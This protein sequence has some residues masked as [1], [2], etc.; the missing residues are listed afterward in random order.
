[1]QSIFEKCELYISGRRQVYCSPR[2][3]LKHLIMFD[4]INYFKH[5]LTE[6]YLLALF[7]LLFVYI[8]GKQFAPF[9]VFV[10]LLCPCILLEYVINMHKLLTNELTAASYHGYN[11]RSRVIATRKCRSVI[12]I[13]YDTLVP[14]EK[15]KDLCEIDH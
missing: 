15:S 8:S 7:E 2:M 6:K 9:Y 3:P 10:F 14:T 12:Y 5:S 11:C 4:L 1:M 13:Y